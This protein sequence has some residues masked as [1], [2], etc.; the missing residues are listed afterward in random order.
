LMKK[1]WRQLK[2][3]SPHMYL[4]SDLTNKGILFL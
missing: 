1:L 2:G 4:I 3:C